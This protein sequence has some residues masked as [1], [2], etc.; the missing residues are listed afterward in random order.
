MDPPLLLLVPTLIFVLIVACAPAT[1]HTTGTLTG[2]EVLRVSYVYAA[3]E[4][5]DTS[6]PAIAPPSAIAHLSALTRL[7]VSPQTQH[8]G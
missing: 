8:T 6:S 2:L 3:A 7:Q 1:A 5:E 4:E